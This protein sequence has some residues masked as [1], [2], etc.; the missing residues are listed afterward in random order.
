MPKLAATKPILARLVTLSRA[1]AVLSCLALPN[2]ALA[3]S[4][5]TP[6]LACLHLVEALAT[7]GRVPLHGVTFDF[8][9]ATLRPNSLPVMIAARDAILTLGGAW[10]IEGHTDNIGSRGQNQDLS[11]ARAASVRNW[12]VSAGVP[13]SQLTAQG[14]SFDQPIADNSID[15]GRAQNRRVELVG[16]VTPDMLGSGGLD[17]VAPCPGTLTL[18]A[19]AAAEGAPPPPPIPD[20]SGTGGQEWLPFSLL[21]A[22]GSGGGQGWGGDR[23]EMRPG[24][25]PEACQAL[26]AA[27]SECAAF[28]FEPAGSNSVENARCALIGYGT[29]LNLTRDNSHYDGGTFYTSGLKPDARLLIPDSEAIAAEIIADLAEIARLRDTVRITAPDVYAPETWMDVAVEGAVPGDA[30]ATYLE[31]T[32]SP[33]YDFD[34]RTSKSSLFVNDMADGRSGQ[35]WVP[36]PGHYTLRYGINHPTAGQHTITAQPFVVQANA[37]DVTPQPSAAES[38]PGVT[39]PQSGRSGTVEPGID[40]PGMDIAQTPMTVADPS[41]CQALC[42]LDPNCAAW[43]Y[44]NPGLQG[45]QAICWTKSGVPDGF[46]NPCCT[47]GVMDQAAAHASAAPVAVGTASLTFPRVVTPGD[48]IPVTYAGPLHSGDWVD[49]ISAGDDSDMSGGWSWAYVTGAPVALTAPGTEGD[50]TLR[51]VAEDPVRGRVVL[52]QDTLVVRVP[53]PATAPATAAATVA[54]PATVTA[55]DIFQR[56]ESSTG[57]FCEIVLSAQDMVLTLVAGYGLTE[58][59]VYETG[60]GAQAQRPSFNLV[61]LSDGEAVIL[62][63]ARHTQTVYCQTGLSG[64]EICLTPAFGDS[65]A[66]LAG[67]VFS[68]LT[69]TAMRAE[70]EAMGADDMPEAMGSDMEGVWFLRVDQ[71]GTSDDGAHVIMVELVNDAGPVSFSGTFIT[72]PDIGPLPGMSGVLRGVIAGDTLNIT[73]AASDGAVGM[74]FSGTEYGS[75]A[76][77]G[78]VNLAHS[79]LSRSTGAIIHRVAGPGED[80]DGPDW[81]KGRPDRMAAAMQMGAQAM[82]G[83]LGNLSGEDRAMVDR[84]GAMMGSMAGGG[85]QASVPASAIS[86]AL[87]G[88]IVEGLSAEDALILIAPH[89]ED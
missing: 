53:A 56:C 2:S 48:S 23:I 19:M 54:A 4:G 3:Q 20:W 64:D 80:W 82:Q 5:S 70:A 8:N 41:M 77:R 13:A 42:A 25:R 89:L 6:G 7:D 46:S 45:E 57:P 31:I 15:A 71:P 17:G 22:T 84:L 63:N 88:T 33:D 12:L 85:G 18:G 28:S 37:A 51:Y 60:D 9:R 44:A 75:N 68:T 62:V 16:R 38:Q 87:D 52:A 36:E 34:W 21:M 86:A 83:I 24:A 78:M 30:Y 10:A 43:T 55:A 72:A 40:R 49:I 27:N 39:A 69:N 47:S 14:F 32:L 11:E 50:Y 26:C 73:M 74:V 58:P 76:Y 29:E 79:P 67:V 1:L 65:D 81:T 66:I 59:L 61:R 35:I